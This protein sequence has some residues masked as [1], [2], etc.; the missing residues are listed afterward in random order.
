VQIAGQEQGRALGA[1][2]VRENVFCDTECG[3][4]GDRQMLGLLCLIANVC[5]AAVSIAPS[6]LIPA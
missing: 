2:L 4:G 5:F 6:V 3:S 1:A